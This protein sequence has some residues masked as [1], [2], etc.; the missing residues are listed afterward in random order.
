MPSEPFAEEH[1]SFPSDSN[2]GSQVDFHGAVKE[3]PAIPNPQ[4]AR[5]VAGSALA[6]VGAEDLLSEHGDASARS[7]KRGYLRAVLCRGIVHQARSSLPSVSRRRRAAE[8]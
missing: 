4:G 8:Y 6:R 1:T 3:G 2:L 5:R 7:L